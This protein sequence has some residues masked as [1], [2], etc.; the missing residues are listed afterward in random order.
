[1]PWSIFPWPPYIQRL[2]TQWYASA[3]HFSSIKPKPQLVEHFHRRVQ[4]GSVRKGAA[5]FTFPPP[6]VGVIRTELYWAILVLQYSSVRVLRRRKGAYKF[7]LH[8]PS[9]D[10]S[11]ESSLPYERGIITNKH[12]KLFLDGES[13]V[14]WKNLSWTSYI[15]AL[16]PLCCVL[17]FTWIY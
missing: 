9:V 16:C 12:S 13:L 17:L 8:T 10:W 15:V 6:K 2:A 7:E 3:F 5:Q 11:P 1:M 14:Y 4:V